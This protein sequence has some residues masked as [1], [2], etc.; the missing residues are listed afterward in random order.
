MKHPIAAAPAR[1]LW[2]IA[3]AVGAA[4][5]FALL[6]GGPGGPARAFAACENP[7]DLKYVVNCF[8]PIEGSYTFTVPLDA[9]TQDAT[10][11]QGDE[12]MSG[13]STITINLD[14]N[15]VCANTSWSGNHAPVVAAHIHGGAYGQPENPA[16]TIP[17]FNP[18]LSVSSPQS[19]CTIAP[20]VEIGEIAKCPQQFAVVVHTQT[21]PAG[22]IRGQLGTTCVL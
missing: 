1:R 6:W 4:I 18:G 9:A 19:Y 11:I 15:T 21:K 12:G 7:P 8:V 2:L 22:A 10:K 14:A 5:A 3:A 17:I 13:T 20:P 16:V